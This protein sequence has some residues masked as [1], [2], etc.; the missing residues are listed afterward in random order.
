MQHTPRIGITTSYAN[1]RQMVDHHYIRAVEAAGGLPVI[2][3][4]L[5]RT[6]S[7]Q[8][9]AALLDGLIMTG[10]PGITAGLISDLPE[11]L[12][13]VDPVRDSGD[14]LIFAAMHDRPVFGICYG[15]Q[16]I[17]AQAGGTIYGDLTRD[18]NGAGNHSA[19]RGAVDH[20]IDIAP[21]SQLAAMLGRDRLT[22]NTYHIQ[23]I[24]EVGEGVKV[25]GRSPDG[26]I[27]AIESRDGRLV[28][29]Q[30][31]PERMLDDTLPLFRAF[32]DRCR[33]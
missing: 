1:G 5:E 14:R 8:A 24:A 28:G 20:E 12:E 25:V 27:E 11:D 26:V 7:A 10:G 6:E 30:F 9:F 15:M 31:H 13:P 2:V 19:G 16:F 33:Q 4:M 21:D 32:V 3:P 22:V 29:V 23:A 18:L 17:N